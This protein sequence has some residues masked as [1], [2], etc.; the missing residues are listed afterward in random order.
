METRLHTSLAALE[1]L[2][3]SLVLRCNRAGQKAWLQGFFRVVSRLGDGMVWYVTLG[4]ILTMG[5]WDAV[6]PVIHILLTAGF[7]LY[8]YRWLKARTSRPRPC[9]VRPD[10][11]AG[12]RA[13]DQWSFP[14]GHTLHA[15]LF[16]SMLDAYFPALGGI[17]FAFAALVALSRPLLGMHYPSDVLAG[18][19]LGGAIALTSLAL[20]A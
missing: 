10:I 6:G 1:R 17:A 19:A 9:A 16:S 14:S 18:G 3:L 7:A 20:V 4:A 15:V 11:V 13:L 12:T 2:D 8:V 5:G